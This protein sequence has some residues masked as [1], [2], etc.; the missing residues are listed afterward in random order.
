M[1]NKVLP[2]HFPPFS[3]AASALV[4]TSAVSIPAATSNLGSVFTLGVSSIATA[5]ISFITL[6]ITNTAAASC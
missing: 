1:I 5:L 6:I 3:A 4:A 2:F